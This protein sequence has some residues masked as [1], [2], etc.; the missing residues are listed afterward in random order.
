MRIRTLFLLTSLTGVFACGGDDDDSGTITNATTVTAGDSSSGTDATN[1]TTVSTTVTTDDSGTD[2]TVST[3]LTT[4]ASSSDDSG[5]GSSGP[6]DSSGS[7]SGSESGG[8]SASCQQ[9]CDLFL[10][11]CAGGVGGSMDYADEAA[12][13]DACSEIDEG[14]AG[15]ASGNTVQCRI[16]HLTGLGN[17][18]D[19]DDAYLMTHCPHGDVTGGG[20]CV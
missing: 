14:T 16:S 9:Y 6:A 4:D 1:A 8:V 12:C 20:V 15:E 3:T 18:G 19:V 2:A 17:P 7:D 11:E 10:D 5:S 13:L